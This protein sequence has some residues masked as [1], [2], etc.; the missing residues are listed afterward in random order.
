M[1]IRLLSPQHWACTQN[2]KMP[3]QRTGC[4]TLDSQVTLFWDQRKMKLT[5]PPGK[6]DN[7]ATFQLASGYERFSAFCAEA[8][9]DYED[10]QDNPLLADDTQVVSNDDGPG[11]EVKEDIPQPGSVAKQRDKDD[12][13]WITPD[14]TTASWIGWQ[15]FWTKSTNH[16]TR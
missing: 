8:E 1:F 15:A 9:M 16:H 14:G 13:H 4:E 6:D 5:I 11:D 7:V 3:I 10:E 12:D 2:D